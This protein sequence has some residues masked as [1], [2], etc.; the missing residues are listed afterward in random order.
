ML[1]SN[2]KGQKGRFLSKLPIKKADFGSQ[3]VPNANKKG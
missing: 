1:I 2:K 3:L